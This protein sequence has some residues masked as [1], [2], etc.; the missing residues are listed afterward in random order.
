MNFEAMKH[1]YLPIII[2]ADARANYYNAL[3]KA[4]VEHDYT[5]FI[6]L[7]VEEEIK[8]LDKYLNLIG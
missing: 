1:G 4:M 3:D 8:I 5:D 7:I 2:C 6:K